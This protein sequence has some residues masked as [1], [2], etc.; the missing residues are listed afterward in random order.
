MHCP[1]VQLV[2]FTK[3]AEHFGA[4]RARAVQDYRSRA[5]PRCELRGDRLNRGIR[6]GQNGPVS[7]LAMPRG[8]RPLTKCTFVDVLRQA[9]ASPLP[10]RPRPTIA[11]EVGALIDKVRGLEM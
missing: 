3:T 11:M 4:S 2:G 9:L 7:A 6:D 1:E 10:T 8:L 5:E